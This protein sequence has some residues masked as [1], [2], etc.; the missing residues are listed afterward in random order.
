MTLA[1]PNNWEDDL[2]GRKQYDDFLSRYIE[3]RCT[4][5]SA[6]LVLAV[7]AAW[8]LGKSFFA[9]RWARDLQDS[10][11]GVV[12]FDAW[13]NDS[14]EDPAIAFMAE[15][16]DALTPLQENIPKDQAL[17]HEVSEKTKDLVKNLRKA[18]VPVLSMVGRSVLKKVT[19]VAVDE[20]IEAV[21]D[22][23]TDEEA[24]ER[25]LRTLPDDIEGGLDAFFERALQGHAERMKSVQAFRKSLEDLVSILQQNHLIEGPLFVFLDEL[26]RCRPDYAIRLLEG[27]KHLFSV[28]GVAFVVSTNLTQ[29][30]KAVGAV[31]GTNFD[32]YT[33]L[34]RFFDIEYQLSE[35]TR[36]QFIQ[37]QIANTPLERLPGHS[38]LDPRARQLQTPA[39]AFAVVAEAFELDLRSIKRVVSVAE[40]AAIGAPDIGFMC[41]WLFFLAT[42]RYQSPSDF[43]SVKK[44]TLS[45]DE[46]R[47]LCNKHMIGAATAPI[48]D[49]NSRKIESIPLVQPLTELYRITLG[50]RGLDTE[51]DGLDDTRTPYPKVLMLVTHECWHVR[52][53]NEDH[54]LRK[55]A[56]L[57]SAAGYI[58]R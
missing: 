45:L 15:L 19:G 4:P 26:D 31:Y 18:T 37:A 42:L 29:L 25:L 11:R 6:G 30:S 40:A 24:S 49:L 47:S 41:L 38:G 55:H 53:S 14:A 22:S 33:Y 58:S 39:H 16:R 21:T 9:Q 28:S 44:R 27:I 48:Y 8:G 10:G 23:Q 51:V 17:A 1:K 2:L 46:F 7:D 32:G 35:P 56:E 5:Q 20:L 54:P 12:V 3:G 57:V 43:T 52:I 50:G 36:L 13:A 34:R